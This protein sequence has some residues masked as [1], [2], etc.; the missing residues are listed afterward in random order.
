MGDSEREYADLKAKMKSQRLSFNYKLKGLQKKLGDYSQSIVDEE[1]EEEQ[2]ELAREVKQIEKD[3]RGAWEDMEKLNTQLT[4]Q[5]IVVNKSNPI[6]DG[7]EAGIEKLFNT[8]S[9]YM[10]KWE[11]IKQ[12]ADRGKLWRKL[13]LLGKEDQKTIKQEESYFQSFK[14]SLDLKPNYLDV[15]SSY[16][17]IMTFIDHAEQYLKTGYKGQVPEEGCSV[18][19]ANLINPQWLQALEKKGHQKERPERC[20]GF[21]ERRGTT[22]ASKT[23]E[24]DESTEGKE[25]ITETL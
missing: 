6:K 7:L 21:A 9:E 2:K 8:H 22:N 3:I 10:E 14:P 24:K 18:H 1:E 15:E 13:M 19:L 25:G 5:I 12:G 23:P 17:E 4:S 20:F 11:A 16:I